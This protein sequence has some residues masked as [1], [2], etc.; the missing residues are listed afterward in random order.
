MSNATQTRT[1][2]DGLAKTPE[3]ERNA[4]VTQINSLISELQSSIKQMEVEARSYDRETKRVYAETVL[5]DKDTLIGLKASLTQI[6]SGYDRSNLIGGKSG[7]DRRRML[8]TNSRLEEQN[9][10]IERMHRTIGEA[11]IMADESVV[12][13][14]E[15]REKLEGSL[16]KSKEFSGIVDSADKTLKSMTKRHWSWGFLS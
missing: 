6:Q 15:N 1:L 4:K 5:R 14:R 2:I 9:L 7:D 16:E 11:T 3:A 8:D 10:T 12:G 13:L